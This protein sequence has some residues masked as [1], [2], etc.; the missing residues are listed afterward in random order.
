MQVDDHRPKLLACF[1]TFQAAA[2]AARQVSGASPDRRRKAR[3]KA[4][5]SE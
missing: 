2:L 3:L 4:A 1:T 5:G